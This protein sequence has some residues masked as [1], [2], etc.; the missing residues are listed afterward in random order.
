MARD[1][2][3]YEY[4]PLGPHLG[5]DARRSANGVAIFA[6]SARGLFETLQL[7]VPFEDH[8]LFVGSVPHLY[9]LARVNDQYPR[10]AAL[11]V[12]TNSARLFR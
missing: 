4:Q 5:D 1:I 3:A 10:Y 9:P 8:W 2:Q 12:D 11:V 7:D 6:C